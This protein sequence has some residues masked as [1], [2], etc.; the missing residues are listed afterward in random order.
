MP[1][2]V[3][4]RQQRLRKTKAQLIE[5]I[6]AL[7]RRA[8]H[9][10]GPEPSAEGDRFLA[11]QQVRDLAKFPSENPN[12]VLRVTPESSVLYANEAARAVD[13]LFAGSGKDRL[14]DELAKVTLEAS[15]AAKAEET[16]FYSR[17]QVFALSVTPI[18]D[19]GYINIYGREITN[20]HLATR[21]LA[22]KESQIQVALNNMRSGMKLVDRDLNYVIFNPRYSELCRYPEG[23]LKVGNSMRDELYFQADRGDFGPGD[24]DAQVERVTETYRSGA[25]TSWERTIVGGPTLDIRLAPTPDGGYVL[26]LADVT[27]R[28]QTEQALRDSREMLYAVIDTVPAMINAKDRDSRYVFMNQ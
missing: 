23:L 28:K 17:D 1:K 14:A 2:P 9:A 26:A 13:G 10:F 15:R 4:T 18:A 27:E 11:D 6:E 7:E 3:T 19:E 12:P 21:A 25:A 16:Q 22:E 5:E 8:E 20:E 24:R